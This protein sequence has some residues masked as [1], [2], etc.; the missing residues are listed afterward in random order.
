MDEVNK[1][2]YIPLYG[3]ARVS[4]QG[5][6]LHDPMAEEIWEAEAFSIKGRSGSKWLA[7]N[8]AMRARVFDD[9]TDSM[10]SKN[11]SAI[12]LHIGCGLDSRCLRV[13]QAYNRWIDCDFPEVIALRK[14]YYA[15]NEKYSMRAFDASDPGQVRQLPDADAAIVILE[16]ISMYLPSEQLSHFFH[17]LHR[18]YNSLHILMDIYTKFGARASRF[19]NPVNEVGV[20]KVYGIDDMEKVLGGLGIR[21]KREYSLTPGRLVNELKGFDKLIFKVLFTGRLYRKIYR[22]F[23]LAGIDEIK[24]TETSERR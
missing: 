3:K 1:T 17:A 7:Y 9:W 19:K 23:E 6:I 13:K 14:K 8:M 15:E 21:V 22:L 2:L 10:I 12:V 18:K 24:R 4:K 5:I 16:G 20:G 11:K